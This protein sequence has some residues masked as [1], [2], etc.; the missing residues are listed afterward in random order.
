M[1]DRTTEESAQRSGIRLLAEDHPTLNAT[2]VV[3]ECHDNPPAERPLLRQ[4]MRAP[5]GP[6][7]KSCRNCAQV[8]VPQFVGSLRLDD[9]SGHD[10]GGHRFLDAMVA[11]GG[12]AAIAARIKAHFDAGATHVCIQPVHRVGDLGAARRVLEALAPGQGGS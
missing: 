2:R 3:V 8:N 10:G 11:W 5:G 7:A 12:E 1:P 4:R 9:G 6:E